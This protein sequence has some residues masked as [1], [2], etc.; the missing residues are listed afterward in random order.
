MY[1]THKRP[2]HHFLY[3]ALETIR[4]IKVIESPWII[5][6]SQHHGLIKNWKK[7]Q[8]LPLLMKFILGPVDWKFKHK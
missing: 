2:L 4:G 6:A 3:H 8:Y 1:E 5:S 7:I